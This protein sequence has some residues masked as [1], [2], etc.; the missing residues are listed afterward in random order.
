MT[1]WDGKGEGYLRATV[2][3]P[4]RYYAPTLLEKMS[5][6]CNI[7]ISVLFDLTLFK[8]WVFGFD[9]DHFLRSICTP[10]QQ[11]YSDKN[12]TNLGSGTGMLKGGRVPNTT[13]Y[14][15]DDRKFWRNKRQTN[16]W[17]MSWRSLQGHSILNSA[18]PLHHRNHIMMIIASVR[19]GNSYRNR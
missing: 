15:R 3:C 19:L 18:S 17:E 8:R 14:D 6:K 4:L 11:K 5:I 2:L 1:S 16:L 12:T 9:Y 7:I 13:A 10:P